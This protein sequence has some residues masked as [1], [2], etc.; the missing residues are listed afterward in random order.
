M[1]LACTHFVELLGPEVLPPHPQLQ[2]CTMQV[3]VAGNSSSS[4][5]AAAAAQGVQEE[6]QRQAEAGVDAEHVFLYKLVH[7]KV[8]ASYGVC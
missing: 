1:L 3:L 4:G 5:D 2:L 8:A 6:E 7:G